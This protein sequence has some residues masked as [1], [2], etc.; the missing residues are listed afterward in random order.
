MTMRNLSVGLAPMSSSK[1]S[2]K[3]IKMARPETIFPAMAAA[4]QAQAPIDRGRAS[5]RGS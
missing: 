3:N 2:L 5:A 4:V 1:E